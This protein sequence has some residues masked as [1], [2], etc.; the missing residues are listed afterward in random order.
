M[1]DARAYR[2]PLAAEEK[3]IVKFSP[4][5][6]CIPDDDEDLVE[7]AVR[8]YRAGSPRIMD[9]IEAGKY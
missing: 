6:F 1:D 2:L 4:E 3:P 9:A 7:R 5:R 8:R